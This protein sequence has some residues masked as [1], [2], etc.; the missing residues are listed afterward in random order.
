MRIWK[1][2]TSL[3]ITVKYIVTIILVIIPVI[4][5]A[6]YTANQ[7]DDM[8]YYG[9]SYNLVQTQRMRTIIIADF[10]Q[11]LFE[12]NAN[13]NTFEVNQIE[14]MMNDELTKYEDTLNMLVEGDSASGMRAADDPVIIH[15]L[16]HIQPMIDEYILNAKALIEDPTNTV[17]KEAILDETYEIDYQLYQLMILYENTYI[18]GYQSLSTFSFLVIVVTILFLGF[19]LFLLRVLRQNEFYANYDNLTRLRSR[20]SLFQD[21]QKLNPELYRVIYM[22]IKN[23]KLI[24]DVYGNAV[25]DDILIQL[26]KRV[27][28]MFGE[29][30]VYRFGGDELA[31]ICHEK[32]F[33]S[34]EQVS[35]FRRTLLEPFTD[36]RGRQHT[37]NLSLGIVDAHV[38]I[39]DFEQKINLAIDL[40]FD[41]S[42]YKLKPM[43]CDNTGSTAKRIKLK[44]SIITAIQNNEIKPYFQPLHWANGEIKGFEALARWD[45]GGQIINPGSFL[46][47]VNRNG[48]GYELDMKMVELVAQ[49]L[50]TLFSTRTD[51]SLHVSINLAI[52]TLINI[53]VE[54]LI[55]ILAGYGIKGEN[56]IFE[57]L[58]DV[59][60]N[61]KT[62]LKLKTLKENGFQIALDDF[63]TGATSFEYLKFEEIDY[64]KIDKQVLEQIAVKDT[65]QHILLDLVNMIHTSHKKVIVEGVETKEEL[66]LLVKMGVDIIQGFYFSKPLEL[67]HAAEYLSKL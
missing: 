47:L 59:I 50:S 29:K 27:Q 63:T 16:E 12:E 15:Q 25:G 45:L 17:L 55:D 40:C 2:F 41:S 24:N 26:A 20:A 34:L 54:R 10:S 51:L 37:I 46:P 62:R 3:S 35:S 65:Y 5:G 30:K 1:W 56:I 60:I 43:I 23:F 38:G 31:I 48:M 32:G 61:D 8:D 22:D 14:T 52:D 11:R 33:F 19:S 21:T 49:S 66:E 28:S 18:L 36:N 44:E 4:F 64:V 9:L 42:L 58:E 53:Q 39:E 7:N 57:I 13:F 67:N 6:V